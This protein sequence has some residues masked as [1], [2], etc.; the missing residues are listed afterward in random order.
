MLKKNDLLIEVEVSFNLCIHGVSVMFPDDFAFK[1]KIYIF[2][3]HVG[4]LHVCF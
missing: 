4:I 3:E 1:D 2:L